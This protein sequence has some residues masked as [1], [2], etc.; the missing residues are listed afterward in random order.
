MAAFPAMENEM[1][2]MME[3][4]M[5]TWACIVVRYLASA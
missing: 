2:N 3:N 5:H 4:A 1:E